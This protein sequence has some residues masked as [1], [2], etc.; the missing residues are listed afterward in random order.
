MFTFRNICYTSYC[1]LEKIALKDELLAVLEKFY[2][3]TKSQLENSYCIV[4][5]I[6]GTVVCVRMNNDMICLYPKKRYYGTIL[7]NKVF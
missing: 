3:Q 5:S 1:S 6:S 2:R 7:V 4:I